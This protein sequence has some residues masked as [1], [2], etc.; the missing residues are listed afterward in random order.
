[1]LYVDVHSAQGVAQVG[2]AVDVRLPGAKRFIAYRDGVLREI[3]QVVVAEIQ[4]GLRVAKLID[5]AGILPG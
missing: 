4:Q 3:G 1:M 5:V 2:H